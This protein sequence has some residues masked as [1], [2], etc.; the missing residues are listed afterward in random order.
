M[1]SDDWKTLSDKLAVD[2]FLFLNQ[3]RIRQQKERE[4]LHLPSV[5]KIQ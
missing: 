4:G 3:E 5:P 1:P 2:T